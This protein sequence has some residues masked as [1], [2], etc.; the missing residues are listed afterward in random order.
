MT[1]PVRPPT[2]GRVPMDSMRKTALKPSVKT[3]KRADLEILKELVAAGSVTPVIDGT[4][5]LSEAH[6]AIGHVGE[7]HAR[8]T[9]VITMTTSS[10]AHAAA[11]A[12]ATSLVSGAA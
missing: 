8:G 10:S 6:R 12:A 5:P 9:V 2:K 4:Y 1:K 3:T 11:P 7:G